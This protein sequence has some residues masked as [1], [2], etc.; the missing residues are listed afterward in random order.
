MVINDL[1]AGMS[2]LNDSQ[3]DNELPSLT[4]PKDV[5]ISLDTSASKFSPFF[6]L[7]DFFCLSNMYDYTFSKN[8]QLG[9]I[10]GK[11]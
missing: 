6:S 7:T 3:F 11:I 5:I 9:R 4:C 10:Y 1:S 8:F 2:L